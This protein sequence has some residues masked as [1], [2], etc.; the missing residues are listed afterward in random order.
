MQEWI[1]QFKRFFAFVFSVPFCFQLIC[2]SLDATF[3]VGHRHL[4]KKYILQ[5][6]IAFTV[7]FLSR[8]LLS[9]VFSSFPIPGGYLPYIIVASIIVPGAVYILFFEHSNYTHKLI[10]LLLFVSSA[11]VV[12][13]IGHQVNLLCT[14]FPT[15]LNLF[16]RCLPN[17]LRRITGLIVGINNIN[18]YLEIPT[19]SLILSLFVFLRLFV[20][21]IRTSKI[22]PSLY[23]SQS[24]YLSLTIA[25]IL[26]FFLITEVGIYRVLYQNQ[27]KQEDRLVRQAQVKLND[28]AYT[29]LKLNQES[30]KRTSI[31]RHDL[32]NHYAYIGNLLKEKQYEEAL[33]YVSSANE[34][35]F[36]DFHIVDCGNYVVSSIRNLELSKARIRNIPLKYLLAVPSVL[37]FKETRLCAL[38]TNLVDNALENYKPREKDDSVDIKRGITDSYLR[39]SVTNPTDK[40]KTDLKTSKSG[41]GHGY[42]I[43]I[44]KSI[45]ASCNGYI[46]FKIENHH[47]IAD[48]RLDLEA[49]EGEKKNA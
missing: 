4:K 27:K 11:Y 39:I 25:L 19:P 1:Y 40:E 9:A 14:S 46:S 23:Q 7:L 8:I 32:K 30:I 49:A 37:P 47:F 44:I 45:V 3:C 16:V 2:A 26:S 22:N 41:E 43:G 42:G 33:A 12:T 38:R 28:S 18:R 29:R 31:A 24:K 15:S 5:K 13:E 34:E 48:V 20:I 6:I 10:K 36:G 17:L 21:T 35:A